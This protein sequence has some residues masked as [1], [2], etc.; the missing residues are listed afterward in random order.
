MSKSL[1]EI[2]DEVGNALD[3]VIAQLRTTDTSKRSPSRTLEQIRKEIVAECYPGRLKALLTR[4]GRMQPM[5][6]QP[7][8]N[9]SS[10]VAMNEVCRLAL[11][12]QMLLHADPNM[13]IPS[14]AIEPAG[15]PWDDVSAYSVSNPC[16]LELIIAAKELAGPWPH[17]AEDTYEILYS[18]RMRQPDE[19]YVLVPVP[20]VAAIVRDIVVSEILLVD[21]GVFLIPPEA[22]I[23]YWFDRVD[24]WAVAWSRPLSWVTAFGEG[25]IQIGRVKPQSRYS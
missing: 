22:F 1:N 9:Q 19:T 14:K 8:F 3:D 20:M 24:D 10:M 25:G 12:Y 6:R 17:L 2:R 13:S 15:V 5:V 11:Q 16:A 7:A 21:R 18:G 4:L 23:R